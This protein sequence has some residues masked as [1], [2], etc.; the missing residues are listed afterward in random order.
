MKK[1]LT[2]TICLFCIMTYSQEGVIVPIKTLSY[3]VPTGTYIKD[4]DNVF[5]PYLGTW[6][7]E[8]NGKTF[9]IKIEKVTRE[10]NSSLDGSYYYEDRLIARYKV[11]HTTTGSIIENTMDN[12]NLQGAKIENLGYPKN[13]EFEF[14]YSEDATKC[15]NT[16]KFQLEGNPAT[17][18][19]KY[20]Y[21]YQSFWI[22]R[23][24]QYESKGDIPINIPTDIM[25]LTRVQ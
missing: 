20:Y 9:V 14:L 4:I 21:F 22:W 5:Q 3:N 19:L 16:A 11:I 18:Q 25:I 2:I 8:S 10:L 13:N 7:G 6:Q 17:N 15:Y 24:C 1:I 12:M 23:D